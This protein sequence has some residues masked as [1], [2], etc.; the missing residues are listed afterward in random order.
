MQAAEDANNVF[1]PLT[2]QGAADLGSARSVA[3]RKAMEVQV[4]TWAGLEASARLDPRYGGHSQAGR[5]M[6]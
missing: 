3:Q 2:Y 4:S 5:T 1:H 6:K